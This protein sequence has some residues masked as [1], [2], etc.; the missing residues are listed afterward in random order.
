MNV[1]VKYHR[2]FVQQRGSVLKG[3]GE[4]FGGVQISFPRSGADSEKVVL[5]GAKECV[6]STK[7]RIVDIMADIDAQ[8]TVECEIPA[9]HHRSVMGQRGVNVQNIT[10][11]FE[12]QVCACHDCTMPIS[13][14]SKPGVISPWPWADVPSCG[15]FLSLL[16]VE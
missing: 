5:K 16:F 10:K 15:L 9:E 4:E 11:D 13:K 14:A 1:P 7:Q 2:H 6:A 12:V 3:L 8:V